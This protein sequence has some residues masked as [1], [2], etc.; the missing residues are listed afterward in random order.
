MIPLRLCD[1][2][3]SGGAQTFTSKW[4]TRRKIGTQSRRFKLEALRLTESM[5]VNQKAKWL[6]VPN[7]SLGNWECFG[8]RVMLCRLC[9]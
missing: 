6:G 5:G 7:L 3:T 2:D 1:I 8:S 4:Q 9:F